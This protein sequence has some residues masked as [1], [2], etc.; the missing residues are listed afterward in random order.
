M[1][2]FERHPNLHSRPGPCPRLD[3]HVATDEFEALRPADE[4]QPVDRAH[5]FG[6][7]ADTAIADGEVNLVRRRVECDG[8]M[9]GVGMSDGVIEG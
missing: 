1:E 6:I 9:G 7:E 5:R 4:S 8:D 2:M 3:A